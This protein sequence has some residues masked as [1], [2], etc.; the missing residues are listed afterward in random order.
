M[1]KNK[2]GT[3]YREWEIGWIF[4]RI[5]RENLTKRIDIKQRLEDVK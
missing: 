1:E 5:I 4:D 3:T 2:R